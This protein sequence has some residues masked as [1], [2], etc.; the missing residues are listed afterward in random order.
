M[1][2]HHVQDLGVMPSRYNQNDDLV[3]AECMLGFMHVLMKANDE[4]EPQEQTIEEYTQEDMQAFSVCLDCANK[5][6][7][8]EEL[9]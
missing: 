3:C 8:V 2:C 7:D 4:G 5:S 9:K 1:T 6:Q